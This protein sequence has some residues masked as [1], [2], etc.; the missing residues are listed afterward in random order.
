MGLRQTIDTQDKKM[1]TGSRAIGKTLP[2]GLWCPTVQICECS[3]TLMRVEPDQ[4]FHRSIIV[5]DQL[6][7]CGLRLHHG[8]QVRR[9]CTHHSLCHLVNVSGK[10]EE[11]FG[12][13]R[14]AALAFVQP[15]FAQE[16]ALPSRAQGL[17]DDCPFFQSK[18]VSWLHWR[19]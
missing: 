16:H 7:F 9:R 14:K 12:F 18:C 8:L 15:T 2:H 4:V 17:H 19:Q 10:K 1:K 11:L 6:V 3:K 13:S 5:D